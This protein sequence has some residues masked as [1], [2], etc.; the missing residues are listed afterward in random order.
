M[1]ALHVLEELA[2][3]IEGKPKK[4]RPMSADS[5]KD[6]EQ[7]VH[8]CCAKEEQQVAEAHVRS[9]MTLLRGIDDL[10]M[11]LAEHITMEFDRT[12]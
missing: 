4:G 6:L 7:K 1:I 5:F 10:T 11:S 2:D 12:P 9:F 8:A 3:W